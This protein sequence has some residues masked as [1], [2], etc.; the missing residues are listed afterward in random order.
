[1]AA[2]IFLY[3]FLYRSNFFIITFINQNYFEISFSIKVKK[4][5][6]KPSGISAHPELGVYMVLFYFNFYSTQVILGR[7]IEIF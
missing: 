5:F 3:I 4:L 2:N 1:M 7:I 6:L